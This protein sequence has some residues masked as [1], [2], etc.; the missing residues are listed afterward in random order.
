M[1]QQP[2]LSCVVHFWKFWYNRRA[3][4]LKV[5]LEDGAPTTTGF[6]EAKHR[7]WKF[8]GAVGLTLGEAASFDLGEAKLQDY[9]AKSKY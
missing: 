6:I 2:S 5:T 4:I 3:R 1:L 7:S 8:A 9:H